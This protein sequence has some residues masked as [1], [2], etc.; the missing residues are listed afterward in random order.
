MDITKCWVFSFEWCLFV[1]FSTSNFLFTF[2]LYLAQLDW[3][4]LPFYLLKLRIS[5]VAF[6]VW[7]GYLSILSMKH[8][9]FSCTWTVLRYRFKN[10][11]SSHIISEHQWPS[12]TGSHICSCP[13]CLGYGILIFLSFQ[14]KMF[15]VLKFS[16]FQNWTM[17]KWKKSL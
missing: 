8:P 5:L 9:T 7:F 11:S 16:W 14:T 13:A 4:T 17:T 1:G 15:M 3:L 10:S 2:F 12:S 6:V